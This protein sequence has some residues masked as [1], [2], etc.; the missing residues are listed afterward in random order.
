MLEQANITA[1]DLMTR[2]VVVAH[3]ETTLLDTVKLMAK[4]RISGL[5]VLDDSGNLV[6]LIT[7]G[8]LVRWHEGYTDRQARWLDML[9]EGYE[10]A[11][12]FLERIQ[13]ENHKVKAVMSRNVTTVTED[14][15][16]HKIA[17]LMSTN[18]IKRVPVMRDGKLAG[19]VARSDLVRAVARFFDSKPIPGAEAETVDEALRHGR[20]EALVQ[21]RTAASRSS[22]SVSSKT[23]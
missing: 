14:T 23:T 5:P 3:P 21:A 19:I 13:Q 17:H 9:S 10:I 2:D 4:H 22:R 15:P 7:E 11:S 1:G 20:E 18:N 8:D 16:A 6:G 12:S